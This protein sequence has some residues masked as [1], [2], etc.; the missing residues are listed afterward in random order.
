[1]KRPIERV[2]ALTPDREQLVPDYDFKPPSDQPNYKPV[3]VGQYF[4]SGYG[5][6]WFP[7]ITGLDNDEPIYGFQCYAVSNSTTKQFYKRLSDSYEQGKYEDCTNQ[8]VAYIQNGGY[9]EP[10]TDLKESCYAILS[11]TAPMR[12]EGMGDI[13]TNPVIKSVTVNAPANATVGEYYNE[14]VVFTTIQPD[15]NMSYKYAYSLSGTG[16]AGLS[17]DSTGTI[18]GTPTT[19]GS[20]TVSVQ[21]TDTANNTRTG[22]AT[23][24]TIKLANHVD[25]VSV[26]PATATGT[27]T[28]SFSQ[29][30]TATPS[31]SDDGTYSYQWVVDGN[32]T[33]LSFDN[34]HSATPTLSGTPAAASNA[35]IQCTVTDSYGKQVVNYSSLTINDAPPSIAVLTSATP[36]PIS[37]KVGTEALTQF[38]WTCDD[39][40]DGSYQYQISY[41]NGSGTGCGYFWISTDGKTFTAGDTSKWYTNSTKLYVGA[42]A[43]N[44]NAT[45]AGSP[46]VNYSVKDSVGSPT[47]TGKYPITVSN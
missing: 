2:S 3:M 42:N 17:I 27:A 11:R 32:V 36:N 14:Y 20:F 47:I 22:T 46:T 15:W 10:I 9:F 45:G 23:A 6:C 5:F 7:D 4:Y 18:T 12:F 25:S 26:S 30:F 41:I 29:K 37:I 21:V 33:G 34:A 38:T 39:V 43:Y 24:S 16:S 28:Q 31:P 13:T 8:F 40:D 19:A 1:M 44:G 35:N